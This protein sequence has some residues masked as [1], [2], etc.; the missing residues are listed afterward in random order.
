MKQGTLLFVIEIINEIEN[1]L[2]SEIFYDLRW[3]DEE[4]DYKYSYGD[5]IYALTIVKELI[6]E[7]YNKAEE[8]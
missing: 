7:N 2:D 8:V 1:L 4:G 3:E 6:E 5:M